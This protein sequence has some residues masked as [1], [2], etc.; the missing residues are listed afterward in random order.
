MPE[1][2]RVSGSARVAGSV[3]A[4][5][6]PPRVTAS[7]ASFASAKG[8]IAVCFAFEQEKTLA[9][10]GVAASNALIRTLG[11]VSRGES[12]KGKRKEMVLWQSAGRFPAQ[13]YLIIGLGRKDDF[14]PDAV[15][16]G[17]G[18]AGRRAILLKAK[19]IV[20]ALP[21]ASD[22]CPI[23][24]LAEAATEGIALGAYKLSK[25]QTQDSAQPSNLGGAE[26]HV[27]HSALAGARRG[28]ARGAIRA[29]AVNLVRDLVNEP[30]MVVTPHRM[31]EVARGIA[32]QRKLQI[33]V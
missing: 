32:K 25:Y 16:E 22:G 1:R 8:D 5:T 17:C 27:G 19:K 26:L 30:A 11:L 9:I 6:R 3:P 23:E 18:L 13:R 10:P 4:G 33:R 28:A 12:F 24:S 31:A 21:A 20:I 29:E 7:A 15:R 14:T 2:A